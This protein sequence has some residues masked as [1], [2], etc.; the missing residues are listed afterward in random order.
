MT[1]NTESTYVKCYLQNTVKGRCMNLF[2]KVQVREQATTK[3]FTE[4]STH[5]TGL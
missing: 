1:G 3:L 4:I 5:E 2:L